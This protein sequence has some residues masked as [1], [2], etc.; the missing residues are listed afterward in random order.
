MDGWMDGWR[1][2][3]TDGR[4]D[5]WMDGWIHCDKTSRVGSAE[6]AGHSWGLRST[7]RTEYKQCRWNANLN[8][9]HLSSV[10]FSVP[11]VV[12]FQIPIA[13]F[14]PLETPPLYETNLAELDVKENTKED[15]STFFLEPLT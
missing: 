3:R 13:L 15:L 14:C 4:K 9:C 12:L 11:R 6:P 10:G 7:K 2:G 8:E 5:G 1:D